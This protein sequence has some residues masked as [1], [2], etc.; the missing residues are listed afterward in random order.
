MTARSSTTG[1]ISQIYTSRRSSRPRQRPRTTTRIGTEDELPA[2]HGRRVR[3][4]PPVAGILSH[5]LS[6]LAEARRPAGRA[7]ADPA[8]APPLHGRQVRQR[9]LRAGTL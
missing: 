4:L 9:A 3:P 7:A 8:T 6:T 1:M 5:A 2:L